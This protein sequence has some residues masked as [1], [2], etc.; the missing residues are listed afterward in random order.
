VEPPAGEALALYGSRSG[1][2]AALV[3]ERKG[4]AWEVE[5]GRIALELARGDYHSEQTRFPLAFV[6][7][8]GRDVLLHATDW[9]RLDA[10]DLRAGSSL[11]ERASPQH[12]LDPGPD[13]HYLDY[14]HGHLMV[15]PDQT[16]VADAGW[17]WHPVGAVASWSLTRWLGGEVWESEDGP[18][19][20]TF[21]PRDYAWDAPMCWLDER[22]LAVWG[23]GNDDL[24]LLN[25]VSIY[26]T[27]SEPRARRPRW[28]A[29][30]A[31]GPLH[32][33][34]DVLVNV[35]E[36]G[37]SFWDPRSGERIGLAKGWRPAAFCARTRRYLCEDEG[38]LRVDRILV[39]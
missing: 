3:D 30:P 17:Q 18:S 36:E 9:N 15:S 31:R 33:D 16:R 13:P 24:N 12:R 1:Q 4:V 22:E 26:D 38:A 34:G 14:F 28:F 6:D 35:G 10:F 37:S 25:A 21:A 20:T 23:Y 5:S 32:L 7:Y 11:T 19:R 2:W 29:G 8:G 27:E 39:R